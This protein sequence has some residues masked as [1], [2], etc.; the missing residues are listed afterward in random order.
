[1]SVESHPTYRKQVPGTS[2]SMNTPPYGI[3]HRHSSRIQTQIRVSI[4]N[5]ARLGFGLVEVAPM[6]KSILI[7]LKL[8]HTDLSYPGKHSA[9][10]EGSIL[11]RIQNLLNV[12]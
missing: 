12:D 1:M 11:V 5:N 2:E 9:D 6:V 3:S 4:S 7:R 10:H 8:M